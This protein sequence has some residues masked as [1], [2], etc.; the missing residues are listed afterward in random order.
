MYVSP[1]QP[2]GRAFP[3]S[4]LV[5]IYINVDAERLPSCPACPLLST[6]VWAVDGHGVACRPSVGSLAVACRA[7]SVLSPITQKM[8]RH[9]ILSVHS[10]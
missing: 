1:S 4:W 2:S 8:D 7:L 3:V 9:C 5:A 6:E 10:P